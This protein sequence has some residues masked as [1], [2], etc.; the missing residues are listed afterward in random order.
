MSR[1]QAQSTVEFTFA[2]IVIMFIIY[3]MVQVFR[4][5]GM[6]LAQRR[7]SEDESLTNLAVTTVVTP[8]SYTFGD[9]QYTFNITTTTADPASEL[10]ADLEYV[11]PMAAVYHGKITNGN[12]SRP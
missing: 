3:G 11:T 1:R 8:Y 4:W 5:T 2:M 12:N 6:D 10:N 7:F 9:R